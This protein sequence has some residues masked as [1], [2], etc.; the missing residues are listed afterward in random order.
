MKTVTLYTK[1]GCHLCETVE[2]T[3][4]VVGRRHRFTLLRRDICE[5]AADFELYGHDVPVVLVN[6]V[7]IARHRLSAERLVSALCA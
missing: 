6:G 5:D 2:A 7:E 1:R 3:L 4:A